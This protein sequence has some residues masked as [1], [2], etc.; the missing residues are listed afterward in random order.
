MLSVLVSVVSCFRIPKAAPAF[1]TM[2]RRSEY[3]SPCL[4]PTAYIAPA[5]TNANTRGRNTPILATILQ[6]T[7]WDRLATHDS[8]IRVCTVQSSRPPPAPKR[9]PDQ[10]PGARN[11]EPRTQRPNLEVRSQN[12]EPQCPSGRV[13]LVTVL[14]WLHSALRS[15]QSSFGAHCAHHLPWLS[16]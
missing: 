8:L 1:N 11:P 6:A 4:H 14:A 7:Q 15:R 13:D 2:G 9:N 16:I 5:A 10:E 3:K 12:W